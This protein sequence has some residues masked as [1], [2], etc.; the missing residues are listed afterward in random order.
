MIWYKDQILKSLSLEALTIE[1]QELKK[2]LTEDNE[3]GERESLTRNYPLIGLS[4]PGDPKREGD[5]EVGDGEAKAGE[6]EESKVAEENE[7]ESIAA[8]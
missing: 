6:A 1:I 8:D 3:K 4:K 2:Q 5:E 7:E